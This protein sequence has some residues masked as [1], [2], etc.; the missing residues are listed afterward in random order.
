MRSLTRKDGSFTIH[1]L[2]PATANGI[3]NVDHQITA[4]ART[5]L[6]EHFCHPTTVT[7]NVQTSSDVRNLIN[8]HRTNG[9]FGGVWTSSMSHSDTPRPS[10]NP[11]GALSSSLHPFSLCCVSATSVA[12]AAL[13]HPDRR[14]GL[15]GPLPSTQAPSILD[16]VIVPP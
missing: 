10:K 9:R 8:R 7:N 16:Y 4:N 11:P 14:T 15:T 2:A 3:T 13:Y 6:S 1:L 12:D 5:K